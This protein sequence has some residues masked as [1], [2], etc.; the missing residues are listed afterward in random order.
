ME[1]NLT[2]TFRG[3][4]NAALTS[5]TRAILVSN[6]TMLVAGSSFVL[7]AARLL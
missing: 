1:H 3:E 4:L 2:A 6:V 7:A 5:R